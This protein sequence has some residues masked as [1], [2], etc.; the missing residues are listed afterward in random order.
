MRTQSIRVY[1][2][3]NELNLPVSTVMELICNLGLDVKNT[4]SLL[5][6]EQRQAIE[7]EWQRIVAERPDPKT[8]I[9]S[10]D[11]MLDR[12][13]AEK[14]KPPERKLL[15]FAC[16]CQRRDE[17]RWR[18]MHD[19]VEEIERLADLLSCEE[20]IE[21]RTDQERSDILGLCLSKLE[22]LTGNVA[23]SDD[24]YRARMVETFGVEILAE[25][26]PPRGWDAVRMW[27]RT[28]AEAAAVYSTSNLAG[29]MAEVTEQA[30]LLRDLLG[31]PFHSVSLD[32][33]WRTSAVLALARGMYE[34][35]DFGAM[36]MLADALEAAGC[37][38]P[39]V[40]LHCRG[41]GPHVRG[42]WV[43]DVLLGKV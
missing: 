22:S 34:S 37:P 41:P 2:L 7:R 4:L 13:E 28:A 23:T 26:S 33:A 35:R 10:F 30:K 24:C 31:N 36:P 19:T 18:Q 38:D 16:A 6:A 21:V 42:C 39:D 25:L 3:A 20:G 40:L 17:N 15:L 29:R 9:E 12:L 11:E 5:S 1:A 43:V 14:L 32:P 27:T 8:Y